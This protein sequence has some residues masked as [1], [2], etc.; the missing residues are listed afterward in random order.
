MHPQAGNEAGTINR[1]N[2]T[3]MMIRTLHI[4]GFKSIYSETLSLWA[5]LTVSLVPMGSAR[6]IFLRL[7]ACLVPPPTGWLMMKACSA[8]GSG[9]ACLDSTRACLLPNRHRLKFSFLLRVKRGLNYR[10]SLLNLLDAPE[11]AWSYKTEFLTDG[12]QEIVSDGVRNRKN[13]NPAS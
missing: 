2:A 4:Q 6:A 11:P 7:L 13:F 9:L 10:V 12:A 5:G 1:K 3:D 8:V